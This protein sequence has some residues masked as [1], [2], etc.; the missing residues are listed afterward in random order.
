MDYCTRS[1][2]Y[3]SVAVCVGETVEKVRNIP[4][5]RSGATTYII[6]QS[7][8]QMPWYAPIGGPVIFVAFICCGIAVDVIVLP[9]VSS[10]LT[11]MELFIWYMMPSATHAQS[12]YI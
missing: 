8:I 12:M 11:S 1:N 3:L 2:V 7:D 4:I 6:I 9:V 5:K 10:T